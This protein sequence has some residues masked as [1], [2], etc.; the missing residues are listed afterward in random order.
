MNRIEEFRRRLQRA[1]ADR[2]IGLANG[3]AIVSDSVPDVYDANYLSVETAVA[4]AGDL[5]A[6][7]ETALEASHHRRVIVEDGSP[8]VAE[9]FAELGFDRVT[10]LVLAH[11]LAPDRRVD[12]GAILPIALDDLIALRTEATLR[13]PWG[14][15]DIAAQLN[16]AKR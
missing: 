7:A 5:A 13:E 12:T 10:H 4:G 15:A 8:G 16:T 1:A 14:D 9:D 2:T 6:D 3:T 11:T